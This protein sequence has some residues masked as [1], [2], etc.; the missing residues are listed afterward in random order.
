M[1]GVRRRKTTSSLSVP[2]AT[3]FPLDMRL[4]LNEPANAER[5]TPNAER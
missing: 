5:R 1:S 4:F 2:M 3:E